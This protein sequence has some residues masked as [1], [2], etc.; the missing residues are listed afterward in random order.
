MLEEAG[1]L[2]GDRSAG[3]GGRLSFVAL[4]F[5]LAGP[6]QAGVKFVISL[7]LANPD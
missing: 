2:S 1:T 7:N 5:H 3:P 4:S 6:A